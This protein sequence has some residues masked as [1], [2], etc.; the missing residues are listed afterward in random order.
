[1][2]LEAPKFSPMLTH[3]LESFEH[4]LEHYVDGTSKS[5]K[6]A[7]LHL[8]HAVELLLKEKC[9][10]LGKSIYKND[11]ST[12]S[13]H[14]AFNSIKKENVII[15][16]QPILEEL[17]DLRNTIQHK[18]LVPDEF[19]ADFHVHNCYRFVKRFTSKELELDFTEVLPRRYRALI[20]GAQESVS[21]EA[22]VPES[23]ISTKE[24]EKLSAALRDAWEA[25][26]Y[27]TQ[28]ISAY[29]VLQQAVYLLAGADAG[30]PNV[31]FRRTLRDA[32]VSRGVVS[33]AVV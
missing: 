1:M 11:R 22:T 13:I 21:S 8:D 33:L 12:L 25:E 9:V 27:T 30:D 19:T 10:R 14:E 31:K 29:S 26:N 4:G 32:A 16:E 3:A 5:R 28:I 15:E 24:L 18:G 17:H 23:G 2:A 20:E 6:F 7:L